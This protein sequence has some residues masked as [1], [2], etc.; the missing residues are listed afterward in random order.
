MN[1]EYTKGIVSAMRDELRGNIYNDGHNQHPDSSL[2][3]DGEARYNFVRLQ[4][5]VSLFD[6]KTCK[7][8]N[9]LDHS[10]LLWVVPYFGRKE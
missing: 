10:V 6:V 7:L 4:H 9:Y 5:E 8:L 2:F 1:D 3:L